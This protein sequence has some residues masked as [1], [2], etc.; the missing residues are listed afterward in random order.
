MKPLVPV[1]KSKQLTLSENQ[2]RV[3]KWDV[4]DRKALVIHRKIAWHWTINLSRLLRI[5]DSKLF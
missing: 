3:N 5:A 1:P 2:D 4:N